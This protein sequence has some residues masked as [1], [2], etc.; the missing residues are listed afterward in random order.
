V[1]SDVD[2]NGSRRQEGADQSAPETAVMIPTTDVNSE[3]AVVTAWHVEDRTRVEAGDLVAEVETSKAVVDVVSPEPGYL[4]RCAR[5]G[6]EILLAEPIG[7]LFE[8]LDALQAFAAR[9]EDAAAQAASTK[10]NGERATAPAIRR[11]EELGIDL[12]SLAGRGLITVKMVEEAAARRRPVEPIPR[13]LPA[14]LDAPIG[15]ERVAL[16]GAGL[17]ATQ[18]IGIFVGTSQTAVAIVD[19]DRATWGLEVGGVPVVGG[20]ERLR[21]L[22]A[23]GRVDSAVICIGTS[24]PARTRLRELCGE[25]GIP[26][27]NAVDPTA[28]IAP[29]VE[30]GRGNLICAFCHLGVG[31]RVGDNNFLSAYNS[32][33]HHNVLGSDIA[34]GP[35]CMTS[36]LVT[37]GDRARL[38]TG[39]FIEPH[40]AIGEGVQVA[41]GAVIVSSVPPEHAVKRRVVTTSVVPIRRAAEP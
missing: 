13:N 17:G 19:D 29:E 9:R 31:T 26:L 15:A 14:P 7:Y 12:A 36:G 32:F 3:T 30:L 1:R 39:I 2:A 27:T 22:H 38:G 18:A 41:S 25:L 23:D 16:I 28:V 10:A 34:T 8:S 5:E 24:V 11:A 33:D 40:V 37:I 4:L 21:E 6:D 20:P 35:G